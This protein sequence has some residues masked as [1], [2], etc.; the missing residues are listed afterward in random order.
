[1]DIITKYK[2]QSELIKHFPETHFNIE[3][4]N[5][6]VI[7][8]HDNVDELEFSDSVASV[9]SDCIGGNAQCIDILIDSPSN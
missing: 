9:A 4:E 3:Y 8:Y 7:I 5:N 1:M 6:R 2:L